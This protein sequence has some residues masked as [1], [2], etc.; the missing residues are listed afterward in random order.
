MNLSHS[1]FLSCSLPLFLFL[2]PFTLWQTHAQKKLTL[3]HPFL[4]ALALQ[5]RFLNL[6]KSFSKILNSFV[7]FGPTETCFTILKW[8]NN[9]TFLFFK[10]FIIQPILNPAVCYYS[11]GINTSSSFRYDGFRILVDAKMHK[12]HIVYCYFLNKSWTITKNRA[13]VKM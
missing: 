2:V 6:S 10:F 4:F 1:F 11:L 12:V 5:T 3:G 8:C 7:N 13:E 9:W